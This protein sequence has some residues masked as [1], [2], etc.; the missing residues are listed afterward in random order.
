MS[1]LNDLKLARLEDLARSP[2]STFSAPPVN[3][4][5]EWWEANK[6]ELG[7]PDNTKTVA[8]AA[9]YACVESLGAGAVE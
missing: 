6:V 4:F 9:W 5:E 1:H 3:A 7:L 2:N 8:E